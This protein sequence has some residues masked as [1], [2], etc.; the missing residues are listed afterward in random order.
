[1]LAVVNNWI[2]NGGRIRFFSRLRVRSDGLIG[3]FLVCTCYFALL[4]FGLAVLV[5]QFVARILC[6]TEQGDFV[7]QFIF[8]R[9][10]VVLRLEDVNC[11]L[12]VVC[13]PNGTR[14]FTVVSNGSYIEGCAKVS[15]EL[16]KSNNLRT[17]IVELNPIN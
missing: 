8:A 6:E 7:T 14:E 15:K 1:M 12:S 4:V 17:G 2:C 9:Y 13:N 16:I 10:L 11:I 5:V 3:W